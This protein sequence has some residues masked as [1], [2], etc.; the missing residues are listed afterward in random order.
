M[1]FEVKRAILFLT[2]TAACSS[3]AI[4]QN[5]AAIAT[6]NSSSLASHIEVLASD[7]FEG[8]K[9]FTRGEDSAVNYIAAEFRKLGLAPGNKGSY[10]QEVAMVSIFSKPSPM[11]IRGSNGNMML[12]YGDDFVAATRKVLPLVALK[13]SDLVFAGYGIVAPEF[14]WNDYAGLDVK[15]KTV[16]VMIN[17]PGQLSPELFRGKNMTY[18][19]RWTYKFEEA[20]RQGAAGVIIIHNEAGASYPWSVVRNGWA[21]SKLHLES[22]DQH[23][24]RTAIEGWITWQTALNLFKLAGVAKAMT[25]QQNR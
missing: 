24:H 15:G 19:G 7:A 6:I 18:Y 12:N 10:F 2:I 11:E 21:N 1:Y 8:R 13:N 17:D 14:G 4:A 3:Q 23:V 22:E 16:V 20:A 25:T 9:P 5:E